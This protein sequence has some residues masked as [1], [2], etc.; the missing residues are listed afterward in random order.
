MRFVPDRIFDR[1]D[2]IT[3]DVLQTAHIRGLVLD[4][5]YTLAP[6]DVP[7]P[8][9]D[10]VRLIRRLRQAGVGLYILSNNHKGRVSLFAKA[11]DVPF[12]CNS[13]KPFPG[14]FRRAVQAMGLTPG[15]TAAVGDQI[16]TDVFGAHLAGL[17]AWMVRP[18]GQGTS[19]FYRIR[20]GLEQPFI[21]RYYRMGGK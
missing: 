13:M 21:R 12:T 3:P 19:V 16:Y 9:D 5:D 7:L 15:E 8:D 18:V 20:R 1:M 6:R 2:D 17:R 14:A 10:T 11:L 4:I